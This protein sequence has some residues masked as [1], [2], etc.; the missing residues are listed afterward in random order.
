MLAG[1]LNRG[2]EPLV[3]VD[4]FGPDAGKQPINIKL[5][6]RIYGRPVN[7]DTL[8]NKRHHLRERRPVKAFD[9]AGNLYRRVLVPHAPVPIPVA[10]V[11]P[12]EIEPRTRPYFD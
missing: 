12:E 11:V 7:A 8:S 10:I 1:N 3:A 4:L 5:T 2:S 9:C 6:A